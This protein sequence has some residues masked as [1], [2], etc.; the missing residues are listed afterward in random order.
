MY[1]RRLTNDKIAHAPR[2]YRYSTKNISKNGAGR[3]YAM[4]NVFHVKS[5]EADFTDGNDFAMRGMGTS[6]RVETSVKSVRETRSS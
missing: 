4:I 2:E 6:E 1:T 3:M 5:R